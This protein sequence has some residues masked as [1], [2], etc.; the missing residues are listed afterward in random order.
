MIG[1]VAWDDHGVA[2]LVQAR[3]ISATL[4]VVLCA[5]HGGNAVDGDQSETLLERPSPP[6][7][8]AVGGE[9]SKAGGGARVS[10]IADVGTLQL[11][12]EIDRRLIRKCGSGERG[13][14][15]AV[16]APA[17]VGARCHRKYVDA[18]RPLEESSAIAVHPSCLR[19]KEVHECYHGAIETAI[20]AL[21]SL[22]CRKCGIPSELGRKQEMG[23][24][25][26]SRLLLL[27]VHGQCKFVD[28]V[29]IGTW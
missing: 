14:V 11:L 21:G 24:K 23:G 25:K 10:R 1:S 9:G 26:Q 22:D 7:S 4:P 27:D 13:F 16:D 5:P 17:A 18:N 28:K 8:S 20:R 6:T 29:L 12:E 15:K 19:A 2:T 3:H